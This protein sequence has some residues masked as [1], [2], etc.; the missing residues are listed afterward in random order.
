ML[1]STTL[2]L[3]LIIPAYNEE[4]YLSATLASAKT[5]LADFDS[6]LIVVDNN[7]TDNTPEIAREHGATVIFEPVNQIARARNAGAHHAI[8]SGRAPE[9]LVFLD[10]DTHLPVE[11]L[12]QAMEHLRSREIC[13][14]GAIIISDRPFPVF[15]RGMLAT[16][17]R[18]STSLGLAA[19]S[20]LFCPAQAF[21]DTG[22]FDERVFAGEEIWFSRALKKWGRNNR[23]RHF[24]IVS[25]PPVITSARKGDM[26]GSPVIALQLFA[27]LL[28]PWI[29]RSRRLCPVWYQRPKD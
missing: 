23:R 9:A 4:A 14:G 17:N 25:A 10:A 1:P 28:C 26:F 13:G 16:W 3:A 18:T 11:T 29:T 22:G 5:A 8:A 20:F 19:G 7:S 27:I 21:L 24:P 6:Q 2:K 12:V 15:V